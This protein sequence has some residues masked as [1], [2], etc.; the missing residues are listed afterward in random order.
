MEHLS[1]AQLTLVE[2][3]SAT[4]VR[5]GWVLLPIFLIGWL[6]WLLAMDRWMLWRRENS[7]IATL[8][9]DPNSNDSH[10]DYLEKLA[11][12]KT[13]S[14]YH[15]VMRNLWQNRTRGHQALQN[16]L[17]EIEAYYSLRLHRHLRTI[18]ILAAISPLLGLLGT[19][20][21]MMH[22]FASI[23]RFGFGNPV[24]MADGISESLLTTQ[25]GLIVA[26][27]LLL[28]ASA[29]QGKIRHLEESVHAQ[30]LSLINRLEEEA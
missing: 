19:V 5:G 14:Y 10:F 15:D 6:A 8:A 23:T 25:A 12:E 21:G 7:Y 13:S 29:M 2:S 20:S 11:S 18:K 3:V 17:A 1:P 24:L 26:F 16:K 9:N 4:L 22:T 27:P 30:A 28:V